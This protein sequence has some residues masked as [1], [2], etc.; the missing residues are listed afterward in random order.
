MQYQTRY[1]WTIELLDSHGDIQE[2]MFYNC[3]NEMLKGVVDVVAGHTDIRFG[4][5]KV[6]GNDDE[7]VKERGYAYVRSDHTLEPEFCNRDLV[8]K[9]IHAALDRAWKLHAQ[10]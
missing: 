8:P 1:E 4:V 5:I 10:R 6:I 7:G 2:V 9:Y 3:P